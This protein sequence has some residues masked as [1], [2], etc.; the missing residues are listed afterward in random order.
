MILQ[1]FVSVLLA[2]AA[3]FFSNLDYLKIIPQS[4]MENVISLTRE[5][6]GIEKLV[7]ENDIIFYGETHNE[8]D[9]KVQLEILLDH[10]RDI[11]K[12]GKIALGLEMVSSDKQIIL[13]EFNSG[14]INSEK[15]MKELEW[16]N[17]WRFLRDGY[18]LVF[19]TA[20]HH[21]MDLIGLNAP[22]RVTEMFKDG[23]QFNQKYI[24]KENLVSF[25]KT[26]AEYHNLSDR[27]TINMY[28]QINL[29]W[30]T[31]MASEIENY[32]RLFPESKIIVFT[33]GQHSKYSAIPKLLEKN[34]P[35]RF[36]YINLTPNIDKE[37]FGEIYTK[38]NQFI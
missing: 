11:D 22:K 3:F 30:E 21:H 4:P 2:P 26:I 31:W 17:D 6:G 7:N 5:N 15:L 23:L 37:Y 12:N 20:H 10:V 14:K 29:L 25:L 16:D 18:R 1:K 27:K 34:F 33:G 13:D 35:N 28:Y 32:L 38:K 36:D 24:E 8:L 9:D 19:D